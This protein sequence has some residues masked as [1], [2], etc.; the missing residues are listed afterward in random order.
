MS[1]QVEDLTDAI[2][3]GLFQIPFHPL[4]YV[5]VLAQVNDSHRERFQLNWTY[6]LFIQLNLF[7]LAMNL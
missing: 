1:K 5:K 7:R 6:L 2:T 3:S 4:S